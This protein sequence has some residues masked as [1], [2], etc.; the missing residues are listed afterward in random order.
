MEVFKIVLKTSR[1]Q[2]YKA[3]WCIVDASGMLLAQIYDQRPLPQIATDMD[4]LEWVERV[5]KGEKPTR[6]DGYSVL[7]GVDRVD[8]DVVRITMKKAV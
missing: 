4:G 7:T 3:I 6:F 1:A 8:A 5:V 2:E